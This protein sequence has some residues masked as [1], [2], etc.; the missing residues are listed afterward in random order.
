MNINLDLATK[1]EVEME[2]NEEVSIG[3]YESGP[4]QITWGI[5][6]STIEKLEQKS[7]SVRDG[8]VCCCIC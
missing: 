7:C 6:R 4:D 3:G 1:E 5:S 8:N 2:D